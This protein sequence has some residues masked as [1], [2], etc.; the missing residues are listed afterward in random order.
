[1]HPAADSFPLRDLLANLWARGA[2]LQC[3]FNQESIDF[4]M[5]MYHGDIQADAVFDPAMLSGVFG[6]VKFKSK[7]DTTAEQAVRPIGL[8][9]DLS[10]PLPYLALLL[11]LGNES[12]YATTHLNI[13]VTTPEAAL[14]G[15]FQKLTEKWVAATSTLA[16]YQKK[17][18]KKGKP[19]KGR[20]DPKLVGM[21]RAA[22]ERRLTIDAY[23]RYSIAVRGAS[24]KVYGILHTAKVE[25]A[26]ATLLS[27]T[28]PSPTAQ[29]ETIQHMRPLERLGGESGHT[30]W[31][32]K[33]YV[34]ENEAMDVD[35]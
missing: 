7:T 12:C 26:F 1:M 19:G 32:S 10:Q 21:Q 15:Q 28:M 18:C 23:N 20:S 30:S 14:E 25:T 2:I 4:L 35:P 29:D 11:E 33:Y 16:E 8:P 6:Q 27:T 17:K 9:R 24:A 5:V 3:C 22:K 31:M 34:G 13:K